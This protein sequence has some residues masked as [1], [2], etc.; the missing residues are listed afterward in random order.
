MTAPSLVETRAVTSALARCVSPR[1]REGW[2][3]F[4]GAVLLV[5]GAAGALVTFAGL[6]KTSGHVDWDALLGSPGWLSVIVVAVVAG[7]LCQSVS[8]RLLLPERLTWSQRVS[9]PWANASVNR[10]TP[11]GTGGLWLATRVF[12]R[13]GASVG[14]SA[15]AL[16][17]LSIGHTLGGFLIGAVAMSV[18][19]A[20]LPQ[21]MSLPYLPP[22]LVPVLGAIAAFGLLGGRRIRARLRQ[23]LREGRHEVPLWAALPVVVLQSGA[24]FAPVVVLAAVLNAFG[25]PLPIATLVLV[26][27]VAGT[28]GS[29]VPL[30][31]GG[32]GVEIATAALLTAA[33]VPFA[34]ASAAV[35]AYRVFAYWLPGLVGL[36]AMLALRTKCNEHEAA[37]RQRDHDLVRR[38]ASVPVPALVGA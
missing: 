2:R 11:A 35:L 8:L 30:P 29:M 6:A 18:G 20:P 17:L 5:A 12:R 28:S 7:Y 16:A 10:V 13:D 14:G 1:L 24:R 4:G 32:G 9:L 25:H 23:L 19:G 27:V 15:L 3:R 33:G 38:P 26:E 31:G 36:P 37:E 34:A 22:W 21:G